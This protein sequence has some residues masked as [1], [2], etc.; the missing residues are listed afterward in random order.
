MLL[1]NTLFVH[2]VAAVSEPCCAATLLSDFIWQNVSMLGSESVN[3]RRLPGTARQGLKT[4]T[5]RGK[6][7]CLFLCCICMEG[8]K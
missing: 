5:D 1:C 3:Y 2:L 4:G 7:V 8:S 6:M